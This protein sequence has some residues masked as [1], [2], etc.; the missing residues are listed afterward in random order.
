MGAAE[1]VEGAAERVLLIDAENQRCNLIYMRDDSLAVD[2]HDA[3]FEALDDRLGLALF[4]NQALDVELVVLLEALGHLVELA[5]DC[6]ELG[7]R[8]RAEPDLRLA[9]TDSAQALGELCQWFR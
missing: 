1:I 6:F 4:V 7:E 3:V 8:L 2:Q 5:R 9:L